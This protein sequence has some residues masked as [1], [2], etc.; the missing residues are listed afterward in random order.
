LQRIDAAVAVAMALWRAELDVSS[1]YVL[2]WDAIR[3][4]A[5]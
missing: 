5:A 2:S 3:E 1:D 4:A